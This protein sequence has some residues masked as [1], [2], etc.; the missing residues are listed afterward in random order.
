MNEQL[1]EIGYEAAWWL[2]QP[3]Y[4]FMVI[5]LRKNVYIFFYSRNVAQQPEPV[6]PNHHKIYFSQQ[7]MPT[8][9]FATISQHSE[10]FQDPRSL[11]NS[12]DETFPSAIRRLPASP[13]ERGQA[14]IINN[15]RSPHLP[16]SIIVCRFRSSRA[17]C[18]FFAT[19]CTYNFTR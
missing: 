7:A 11:Q 6:R 16:Y 5:F 3:I 14:V 19:P 9:R 13:T 8:N 10:A 2:P 1:D 15:S 12:L 4:T 18:T 17:C